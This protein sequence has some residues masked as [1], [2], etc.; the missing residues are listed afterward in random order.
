VSPLIEKVPDC[1]KVYDSFTAQVQLP[2]P[3]QT[4]A[5]LH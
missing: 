1:V 2:L 4:A 5:F 3:V